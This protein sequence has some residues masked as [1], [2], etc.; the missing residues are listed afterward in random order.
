MCLYL[1]TATYRMNG[2]SRH[3]NTLPFSG[4]IFEY[5]DTMVSNVNYQIN[6]LNDLRH[7]S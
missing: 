4:N 5:R 1:K 7:I 2:V 6:K 3:I